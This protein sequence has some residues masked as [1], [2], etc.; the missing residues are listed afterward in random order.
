VLS[1]DAHL[2][3]RYE[4]GRIASDYGNG[5]NIADAWRTAEDHMCIANEFGELCCRIWMN[6]QEIRL[7][8]KDSDAPI[9]GSVR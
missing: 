4:A 9:Y 2:T 5:K 7:K 6:E 8:Y 1:D 3:S